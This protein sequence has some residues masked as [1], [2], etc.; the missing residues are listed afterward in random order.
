MR[1]LCQVCQKNV[2]AINGYHNGKR[3]YRKK[4]GSCIRNNRKIPLSI[5]R[6][7]KSGYKKKTTCNRCGFVARHSTQL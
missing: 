6:W 5:P 3:Y 1:P 4:C 7:Q 2:A